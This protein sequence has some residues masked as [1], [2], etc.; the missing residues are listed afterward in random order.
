[1]IRHVSASFTKRNILK[2]GGVAPM[3]W[4]LAALSLISSIRHRDEKL[5]WLVNSFV[6]SRGKDCE[7]GSPGKDQ[8]LSPFVT[9]CRED[10]KKQAA[11][12]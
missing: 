5:G 11:I 4:G 9:V 6:A 1:M 8:L 2:M 3:G 12:L 7:P 10:V